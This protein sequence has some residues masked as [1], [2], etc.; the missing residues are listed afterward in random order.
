M[1]YV[2]KKIGQPHVVAGA[3]NADLRH[4]PDLPWIGST[5]LSSAQLSSARLGLT[6]YGT[7]VHVSPVRQGRQMLI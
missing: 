6:D 3:R 4:V 7:R 5:Q 2:F 1:N